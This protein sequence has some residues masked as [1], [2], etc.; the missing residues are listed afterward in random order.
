MVDSQMYV[1]LRELARQRHPEAAA[2]RS[3]RHRGL[4]RSARE[5]SL[6]VRR[7]RR[8]GEAA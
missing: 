5:I 2:R 8:H 4:Q 1:L 7:Q 6:A 3:D